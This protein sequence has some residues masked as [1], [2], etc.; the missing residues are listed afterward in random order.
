MGTQFTSLRSSGIVSFG[1]LVRRGRTTLCFTIRLD[2]DQFNIPSVL[3]EIQREF[4]AYIR[5]NAMSP[6]SD[7]L[8]RLTLLWK[9]D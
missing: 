5:Q 3:A 6:P 1:E 8:S 2:A 7:F 9:S 4:A